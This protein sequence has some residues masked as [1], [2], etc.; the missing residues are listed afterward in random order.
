VPGWAPGRWRAL[1]RAPRAAA[2]TGQGNYLHAAPLQDL[3]PDALQ[4]LADLLSRQG[5]AAR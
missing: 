2:G 4:G 1:S 3:D 5:V